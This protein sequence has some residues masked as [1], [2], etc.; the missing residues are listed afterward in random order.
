MSDPATD[1]AALIEELNLGTLGTDLFVNEEPGKP[2]ATITVFDS[3][4]VS[5][6]LTFDGENIYY[7]TVMVR[8][9]GRTDKQAI[10]YDLAESI[11]D[12]LHGLY[13]TTVD[14]TVYL[15]V[16]ASGDIVRVGRDENNRP[17]FTVNFRLMR[18]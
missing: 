16:Q 1:I 15:L 7:P 12:A 8:V 14:G 9:R 18:V 3:G 10:T 2:D 6:D 11:R 17:M 5:P 13:Q 4:G